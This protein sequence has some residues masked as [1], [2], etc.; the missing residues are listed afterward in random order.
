[1]RKLHACG[2]YRSGTTFV[3][4][5]LL[6][7]KERFNLNYEI[8]EKTHYPWVERVCIEDKSIYPYRN[9]LNSCASYFRFHLVN[10]GI[11]HIGNGE[12]IQEYDNNSHNKGWHKS[13]NVSHILD[14]CLVMDKLVNE[15]IKEGH[16]VLKI[17]YETDIFAD[18][19]IGIK[20]ILDY[21]NVNYSQI[22]IN[23]MESHLNIK[24]IKKETDKI[25]KKFKITKEQLWSNHIYDG[26]SY[27]KEYFPE[28]DWKK[29]K[30]SSIEFYKDYCLRYG[31]EFE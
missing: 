23:F 7:A 13:F 29:I 4:N 17:K 2:F 6:L 31:Y 30:P 19:T 15:K 24:T 20:K 28:F 5:V 18:C 8:A 1:M 26:V 25:P 11:T 10:E 14:F 22:D 21:L 16:N 27:Y 9:I 3:Y 12:Y